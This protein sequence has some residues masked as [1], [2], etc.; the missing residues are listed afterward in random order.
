MRAKW[1]EGKRERN[2]WSTALSLK[3]ESYLGEE[4][5]ERG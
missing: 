4:E 1:K 2:S 3:I 5:R